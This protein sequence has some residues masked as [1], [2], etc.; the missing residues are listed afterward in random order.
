MNACIMGLALMVCIMS[1]RL[2]LLGSCESSIY[3]L[4]GHNFDMPFYGP[5]SF[6][7]ELFLFLLLAM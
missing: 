6:C 5:F 7:Q 1:V 2:C 4:T 3:K